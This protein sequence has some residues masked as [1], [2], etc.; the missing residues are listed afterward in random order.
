MVLTPVGCSLSETQMKAAMEVVKKGDVVRVIK[1]FHMYVK[2]THILYN[3]VN[4]QV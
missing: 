1:N 2:T 3:A 4:F